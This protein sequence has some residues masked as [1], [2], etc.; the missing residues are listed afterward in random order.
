MKKLDSVLLRVKRPPAL[1]KRTRQIVNL[2]GELIENPFNPAKDLSFMSRLLVM[3]NLPY[4]DPGKDVSNWWRRNGQVV[5]NITPGRYEDKNIGIPYG[6]YPRLILAYIITQGVKTQSPII[7]LGNTFREFL[8]RVGIE[9]GGHQY[10]QIKKQL[11]RIFTAA[12]SWSYSNEKQQMW[13]RTN[14]QVSHKSQLWWDPKSPNQLSFLDS[15]V[16]LNTNFFNEI[17]R[18]PVPIDFRV[19]K[20]LKNS[21]LGL[22][23][24]MFLAWRTFNLKESVFISWQSLYDQLGGQYSDLKVFARD[25]R[26]HLKRIQGIW[27]EL[28]IKSVRGRLCISPS[29]SLI[30]VVEKS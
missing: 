3:V 28:N 12:F 7:N 4:K 8:D 22:D 23:L 5:L 30:P 18:N 2:A 21:P 24:Y 15:Y 29:L 19:L 27:P 16:E 14:I 17:I 13:S 1:S 6:S 26:H 10:R 11:D 20:G 9:K 25:C